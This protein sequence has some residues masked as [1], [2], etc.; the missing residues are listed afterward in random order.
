MTGGSTASEQFLFDTSALLAYFLD[1]PGA[2]TAADIK[3]HSLIPFI[4]LSELYYMIYDRCGEQEADRIH[5]LVRSWERPLLFPSETVV[6]QAGEFKAKYRLGIADS[7]I[8]AI[9]FTEKLTLLTKDRDFKIL[10]N[11]ISLK[12]L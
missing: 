3:R 11:A 9:A 10:R 4:T 7:Y 5:A 6:L 8:A 2:P 1:E 12:F